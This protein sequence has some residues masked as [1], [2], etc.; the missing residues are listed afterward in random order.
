VQGW[1]FPAGDTDALAARLGAL[2]ADPAPL[3]AL[4]RVEPEL[5]TWEALTD[6]MLALY[7]AAA[8]EREE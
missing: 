5:P 3:A 8:A 4:Y 7:S 1:R 6:R 2:L